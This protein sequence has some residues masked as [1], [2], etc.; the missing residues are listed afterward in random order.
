MIAEVSNDGAETRKLQKKQAAQKAPSTD[1]G[2]EG[3]DLCPPG[4]GQGS[5][6]RHCL[7]G[8]S[9]SWDKGTAEPTSGLSQK[10]CKGVKPG[11]LD[12]VLQQQLKSSSSCWL[13][14]AWLRN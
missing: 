5:Q 11:P 14:F 13:R 9:L 8:E 7:E 2:G 12:E 4:L 1:V 6:I 3:R 10:G